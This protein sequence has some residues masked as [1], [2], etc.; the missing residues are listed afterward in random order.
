LNGKIVDFDMKIEDVLLKI[1]DISECRFKNKI[2]YTLVIIS[3]TIA[4]GGVCKTYI[5]Y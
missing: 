1:N 4:T 2:K 5:I 3:A